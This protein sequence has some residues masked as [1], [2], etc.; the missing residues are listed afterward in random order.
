MS[1]NQSQGAT[2]LT[3][4]RPWG[5]NGFVKQPA[6]LQ[7]EQSLWQQGVRLWGATPIQ[8]KYSL[9]GLLIGMLNLALMLS[10]NGIPNME[11][12]AI[13]FW[14]AASLALIPFHPVKGSLVYLFL[15]VSC[16]LVPAADIGDMGILA[17]AFGFFLGRFLDLRLALVFASVVPLVMLVLQRPFGGVASILLIVF[18]PLLPSV[19]LR[20]TER[21]WRQEVSAA[22]EQL[23]SIRSEVAREMHDLV[24]YSMSQTALRAQRAASDPSYPLDARKEFAAIN[25]TASDALHELRLILR[26]LRVPEGGMGIASSGEQVGGLGTVVLDLNSVV[27]AL[28]DD[29]A[30]AGYSVSY[31]AV[32]DSGC[33][34]L[35]A[36][37]L[38]R[39]AREMSSNIVRHGDPSEPVTITLAQDAKQVRLVM[40]NGVRSRDSR[41]L[42]SSGLGV[43][44]MR[45][46][47]EMIGGSLSTVEDDGAWMVTASAPLSSSTSIATEESS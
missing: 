20:R 16:L 13:L 35:Q 4:R 36:T 21:T 47:L 9:A 45:E 37:A 40:T 24:A 29:I 12:V 30:S 42:P 5:S 7:A 19:M 27:R 34:R 32:G 23:E 22:T 41:G 44:G 28:A 26:A 15:W 10:L 18:C 31:Q 39:V 25:T 46:R 6:D 38:S 2:S 43:L 8:W 1:N 14:G 17:A 11:R 3:H 33:G